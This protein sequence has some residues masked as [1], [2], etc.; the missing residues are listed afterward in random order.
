M[1]INLKSIGEKIKQLRENTGFTQKNIA[2]FLSCDQSLISKIE[3]GERTIGSAD[4]K[5]LSYL[6]RYPY[7]KFFDDSDI[8]PTYTIAF[9]TNSFNRLDLQ[10]LSVIN[11][12]ILNQKTM[13]KLVGGTAND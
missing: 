3:K 9:R 5:Q 7:S 8:I 12:I 11:K 10:T 4:L 1:D 13:D 2:E 6:F